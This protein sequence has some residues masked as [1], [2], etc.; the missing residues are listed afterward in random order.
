MALQ[1]GDVLQ[2]T[3]Q[4]AYLEQTFNNVFYYV[5][6]EI[7]GDVSAEDVG[8]VFVGTVHTSMRSVQNDNTFYNYVRIDEL[9][10]GIDFAVITTL[11]SGDR[12]VPFTD[13]SPSYVSVGY[14]FPPTSKITRGGYKRF[15]G[16]AETD[17]SGNSLTESFNTLQVTLKAA[18]TAALVDAVG[19]DTFTAFPVIVGRDKKPDGKYEINP[20][21][22][23]NI[24]SVSNPYLTSQVSRRRFN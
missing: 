2:I 20:L 16:L 17:F 18:L 10:R 6:G 5:I 3:V 14:R 11:G 24:T 22:R 19:P 8:N 9:V 4:G 21:R 12:V 23:Q 13:V 1:L 7:N 15:C